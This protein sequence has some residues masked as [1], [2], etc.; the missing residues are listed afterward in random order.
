MSKRTRAFFPIKDIIRKK[1]WLKFINIAYM[2]YELL[3]VIFLLNIFGLIVIYSASYYYCSVNTTLEGNTYYMVANQ[4]KYVVIGLIL[5]IGISF[6][7]YRC[8]QKFHL[9]WIALA[10]SVLVCLLLL[11][12]I[13][14]TSN[15]AARW[16]KI[17]SLQVQVAE[18]VKLGVIE[19]TAVYLARNR[20]PHN[21]KACLKA[22]FCVGVLAGLILVISSDLS[23]AIIILGIGVC[24]IFI[25]RPN[26]K[27]WVI[28]VGLIILASVFV[29]ALCYFFP[30]EM[31]KLNY[32]FNRIVAWLY[33]EEYELKTAMQ[34]LYSRFA[35]GYGGLLGC[36]LGKS[37]QKY[38][39][40]EPHNDFILGIVAEELGFVGVFLLFLLFAYLLYCIYKIS[41]RAVD[42]FGKLFA[43]G[44]MCQ[45]GIQIL[46][47]AAVAS[48]VI[49]TTGVSLPFISPGGSS[50]VF[51]MIE[52]GIV[53]S[54]DK[55]SN[56]ERAKKK[57]QQQVDE[58]RKRVL[59]HQLGV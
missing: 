41:Y 4:F 30:D 51:I 10:A 1:R 40:P 19:F 55:V 31:A 48:Y 9:E 6:V 54:I 24:M 42:R 37:L 45:L 35:I 22:F 58:E 26:Y 25:S 52:I 28:A 43:I 16:L 50:V 2:D 13:K 7:D 5:M 56:Q 18:L 39:L 17:G 20:M 44:V 3:T 14:V 11:T 21:G 36:G 34:P 33:Q 53:M 29:V 12:P 8:W 15:E 38:K 59:R 32:R 23:S 46:M 57:A 49:P 47:N 27:W